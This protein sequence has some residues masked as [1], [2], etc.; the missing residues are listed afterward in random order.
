VISRVTPVA[1]GV[2]VAEVQAILHSELDAGE[3]ARD[4]ARNEGLAAYWRLVVE[5]DPVAGIQAVGL[6]VVDGDPVRVEFRHAVG[7]AGIKG[8]GLPLR[9]FPRQAEELGGRCLVEPGPLD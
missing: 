2:E 1:L 3:A 9:R 7:R 5:E 4:L 8:R 6:A